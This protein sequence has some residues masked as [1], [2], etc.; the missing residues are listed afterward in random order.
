MM[1]YAI[2]VFVGAFLLFQVQPL[3]GRFILPWFGG[4]PSVWTACMLFFQLLLLLGYSYAHLLSRLRSSRQQIL[5]HCSLIAGS[6]LLL[7]ISPDAGW[8]PEA[9]DTPLTRILVLLSVTVGGP[10]LLLSTTGPLMQRWFSLQFPGRSPYRFYAL[11]NTG[12]LLAL[13]SYPLLF[14]P[15]LQLQTQVSFWGAGYVIYSAAVVWCGWRFRRHSTAVVQPSDFAEIESGSPPRLVSILLWLLLSAAGSVILLATTNQ[16]CLDVATVPF[17]WVLPLSLY[18]ITFILCFDHDRWYH[19]G[20]NGI[21]LAVSVGMATSILQDGA[22]ASMLTQIFTASAALLAC[23]MGCHGE[24]YRLRPDARYLTLYF[25][26]VSAGGAVGGLLTALAA[27]RIFTGYHE[28][29][30]ALV[31]CPLLILLAMV[32]QRAWQSGVTMGFAIT[33]AMVAVQACG[34]I[35]DIQPIV[36]PSLPEFELTILVGVAAGI[37]FA[38]LFSGTTGS[39]RSFLLSAGWAICSV[40]LLLWLV[41]F[42]AWHAP[43]LFRVAESS[44]F[45]SGWLWGESWLFN[46]IAAWILIPLAAA[47]LLGFLS[48]RMSSVWLSR[49]RPPLVLFTLILLVG[50]AVRTERIGR[51]EWLPLLAAAAGGLAADIGIRFCGRSRTPLRGFM[52]YAPAFVAVWLHGSHLLQLT[53]ASGEL[54]ELV[55]TSRNFYGVLSVVRRES[56]ETYDWEMNLLPPRYVL[57][58]GQIEHGFQFDDEYWSKQPTTYYGPQSGLAL[59]IAVIREQQTDAA[60]GMNMGVIGLGTGTIAACGKEGDRFRF[61]EINPAV[62]DLAGEDGFFSYIRDSRA[63]VEIVTGDARIV[64]EREQ[65]N[66][67]ASQYDVLAVDAFSSDAIPVHL[68]TAECGDLYRKSLRPD[69]I[70]AIHISNR[71]LDLEPVTQGLARHLDWHAVVVDTGDDDSTGSYGATWVLLSARN[72]TADSI[73]VIQHP[74]CREVSGQPLL[75]TDDYSGLWKVLDW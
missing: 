33:L 28:Y 44:A 32:L 55:Q 19:R 48:G 7:P 68:L 18:L 34:L 15:L 58:H 59:A 8:K 31:L 25:V 62:V 65:Q 36:S 61:Y 57:T 26:V 67:S 2:T 20:I 56:D 4:G 12:S 42:T 72:L 24:L 9:A 63:E 49:F 6:L 45:S 74:G 23:C 30:L 1:S 54:G 5:L 52:I 38:T 16:L 75:W 64:M 53:Q 11:S 22:D 50:V 35:A 29:P 51:E 70:L 21:A 17:L 66:G 40:T 39:A 43:G 60:A 27:P 14:E 37:L 73:A 71:F 69:G 41:S 47:L 10:Y 13:L 3:T 46:R